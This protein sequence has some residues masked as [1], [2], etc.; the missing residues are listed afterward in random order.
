MNKDVTAQFQKTQSER[1][2]ALAYIFARSELL[3][4]ASRLNEE[5]VQQAQY[6]EQLAPSSARAHCLTVIASTGLCVEA[7][8]TLSVTPEA[9][10]HQCRQVTEEK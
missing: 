8:Q 2:L 3:Q 9:A 7:Q 10:F 6:L 5:A 4:I 1:V